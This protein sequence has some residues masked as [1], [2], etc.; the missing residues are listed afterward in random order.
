MNNEPLIDVIKIESKSIQQSCLFA[1][2]FLEQST[3]KSSAS[4]L[5]CRKDRLALPS[6]DII[7]KL[8]I[9]IKSFTDEKNFIEKTLLRDVGKIKSKKNKKKR[10]IEP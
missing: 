10:K 9:V 7:N 5:L 3:L 8:E 4:E 6:E 2:E 1:Q